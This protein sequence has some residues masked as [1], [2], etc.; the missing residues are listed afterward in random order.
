MAAHI[1]HTTALFST[2]KGRFI[3]VFK[4]LWPLFALL[5]CTLGSISGCSFSVFLT[6]VDAVALPSGQRSEGRGN[7]KMRIV[8]VMVTL[9][10]GNTPKWWLTFACKVVLRREFK[11]FCLVLEGLQ[12]RT[13][14]SAGPCFSIKKEEDGKRKVV[15]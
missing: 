10:A 1:D 5:Y 15:I 2:F 6:P 13:L 7:H 3:W 11:T 8:F 9:D 12:L 4:E 14:Q